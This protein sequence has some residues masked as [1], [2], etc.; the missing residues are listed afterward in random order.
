MFFPKIWIF[1]AKND[2]KVEPEDPRNTSYERAT[3]RPKNL[4]GYISDEQSAS[5]D[6]FTD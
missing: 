2:P 4:A 6:H 3:R 5:A 1:L